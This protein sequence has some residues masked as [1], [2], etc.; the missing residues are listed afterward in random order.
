MIKIKF[1]IE[2]M[3]VMTLF[4]TI[5][6][7]KVKDVIKNEDLYIF[8]VQ[9]GEIGKAIGKK[10]ANVRKLENV[11][12]R[13]VRVIEYSNDLERFVRNVI[14]PLR[15][16]KVEIED[17]IV[18]LHTSDTKT[19]GYLIGRAASNLRNTESIVKRHFPIDEIKVV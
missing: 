2:L 12:K 10:A 13:K 19:R 15:V 18:I 7:S 6:R 9:E 17:A 8:I 1:D 3:K 11:L 4:E 16:E 14:M 5:T